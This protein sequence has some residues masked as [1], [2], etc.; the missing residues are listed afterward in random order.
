MTANILWLT[1]FIL[2]TLGAYFAFRR[3]IIPLGVYLAF[4]AIADIATLGFLL[5]AG[6]G[7]AYWADFWL[8]TVAYI[9]L[10]ALSMFMVAKILRETEHTAEFYLGM[11]LLF[12]VIAVLYFHAQPLTM[13][14]VLQFEMWAD[15]IAGALVCTAMG[16]QELAGRTI[17]APFGMI[18]LGIA[19]HSLSDGLLCAAQYRGMDTTPWYPVG[20]IA[21]LAVWIIG[22]MRNWKL[23][24]IA[25]KELGRFLIAEDRI[26]VENRMVM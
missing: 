14:R 26:P 23:E 9:L 21:A 7:T 13:H 15:I 12:G 19:I 20:A 10:G 4:R 16:A 22:P 8:R 3:K 18:A 5:F 2:E 6:Q 1:E 24:R 25:Q 17:P 11:T